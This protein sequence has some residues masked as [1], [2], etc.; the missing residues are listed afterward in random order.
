M[1]KDFYT[2]CL[3]DHEKCVYQVPKRRLVKYEEIFKKFGIAYQVSSLMYE[4]DGDG[5]VK[6]NV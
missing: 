3:T 5:N 1:R 6:Y 2:I 4:V